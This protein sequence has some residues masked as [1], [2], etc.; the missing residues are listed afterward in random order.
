[1][2]ASTDPLVLFWLFFIEIFFRDESSTTH[3]CDSVDI[4]PEPRFL[5]AIPPIGKMTIFANAKIRC[6]DHTVGSIKK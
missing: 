3:Y 4:P 2:T 5:R 6:L 1:M